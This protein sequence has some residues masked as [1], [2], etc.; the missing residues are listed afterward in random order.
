MLKLFKYALRSSFSCSGILL[1]LWLLPPKSEGRAEPGSLFKQSPLFPKA[2]HRHFSSMLK[3]FKYALRSSFHTQVYSCCCGYCRRRAK[4]VER[5][6]QFVRTVA[7]IPQ[8]N[9]SPLLLHAQVIQICPST[10]V[11]Y[12]DMLLLSW[13][14]CLLPPTGKA[15]PPTRSPLRT[16]MSCRFYSMLKSFEYVHRPLVYAQI[17]WFVS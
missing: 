16:W 1:W 11:S 8:D 2:T 10:F 15:R 14:L 5:S 7:L 9:S 6:E 17:C 13:L 4:A 3:S 12:W